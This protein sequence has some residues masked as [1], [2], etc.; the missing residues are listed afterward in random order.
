M[1]ISNLLSNG[2]E[3]KICFKRERI[4]ASGKKYKQQLNVNKGIPFTFHVAVSLKLYQ[5]KS[6]R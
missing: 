5:S 4:K 1:N 3:K 6:F 2:S